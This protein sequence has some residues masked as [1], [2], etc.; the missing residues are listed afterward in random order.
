[1]R[2]LI[3]G[4]T[5]Y[6]GRRLTYRLVAD[7]YNV[8]ALVRSLDKG[9]AILPS[10]AELSAGDLLDSETLAPAFDGVDIVVYLVHSMGTRDKSFE[11]M[12]RQIATGVAEAAK[13][14]GTRQIVYLGGLGASSDSASA[15]LRSRA[16]V[17]DILR[18]SQVPVTELRAAVVVG[19][20]SVSFQMI[21]HL[22]SRL[23]FMICPRWVLVNTQPIAI[24]DALEYLT[25]SI[26]GQT[27]VG[28]T[29]DIGGP[30]VLSY[31]DMMVTV[32]QVMNLRRLIIQV[33]VLT[34]RL[35]SYWVNL[36][37]PIRANL[38]R[39]LIES[40]RNETVC[41]DN[42]R[43]ELFDFEPMTF[44][45]AVVSALANEEG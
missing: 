40:V 2:V 23:P 35:S 10:D 38:A 31:R 6:V 29:I 17:G 26:G 8:R 5:G 24:D 33:P 34:P 45:Q 41:S 19:A 21:K 43:R 28:R 32:A 9:R 30:D 7:G 25:R 27:V 18:T 42:S 37:T 11:E 12:D 14:Q 44:R 15:H 3:L 4:A 22:V 20:G 36:V 39:E 16:E 13:G 1:M